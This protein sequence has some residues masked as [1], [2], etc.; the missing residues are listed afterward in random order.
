MQTHT[1][2]QMRSIPCYSLRKRFQQNQEDCTYHVLA[3]VPSLGNAILE[4]MDVERIT[5]ALQQQRAGAK[6][7]A[8]PVST[9]IPASH[10]P[11]TNLLM[12][13]GTLLGGTGMSDSM[14]S[15][16]TTSDHDASSSADSSSS[17]PQQAS[18]QPLL[19]SVSQPQSHSHSRSHS[20]TQN[21]DENE[22]QLDTSVL[23][24]ASTNDWVAEF[25]AQLAR[26]DTD[27]D[28]GDGGSPSGSLLLSGTQTSMSLPETDEQRSESG[29]D[30]VSAQSGVVCA[31]S[32]AFMSLYSN[33]FDAPILAD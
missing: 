4:E 25:Q 17:A 13:G 29:R 6:P 23:L 30:S 26:E 31:I 3:L 1:N 8:A 7:S 15:S 5:L 14:I 9:E 22:P 2:H 20:Q 10:D 32:E 27:Q 18:S 11:R 24:N 19:Q 16:A 12:P 21:L 28:N 33:E